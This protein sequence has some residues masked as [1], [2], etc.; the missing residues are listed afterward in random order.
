MALF[1]ELDQDRKVLRVIVAESIE[2]PQTRLGGTWVETTDADPDQ[3]Y[4]GPGL[5]DGENVPPMRF[6]P[7]WYQ[8]EGAHDAWA[9][10]AWCWY[11][12]RCWRSL[13]DANVFAPGVASWREMLVE[14]PEYVQPS[15]AQDAYQAGEKISE[16]GGRYTCNTNGTV[17]PPSVLPDA[18]D[19]RGGDPLPE[20]EPVP[21]PE[22]EPSIPRW[23]QPTGS[24]DAPN[25]GD[26]R[27]HDRPQDGGADWVF[28]SNINANTT[29]PGRDSTFDRWWKPEYRA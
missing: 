4:A 21:E 2:W 24:H 15:G 26:Q 23:V 7:P 14:W 20:P 28:T 11:E 27:I 16:L 10:G 5:H 3:Q 29:E 8:P 22:P 19:F 18:W 1:A 17:W 9:N 12:G 13:Q 6:I 25:I